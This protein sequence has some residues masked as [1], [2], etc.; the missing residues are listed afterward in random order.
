M[1]RAA[2]GGAFAIASALVGCVFVADLGTDG[3]QLAPQDAAG[4][5]DAGVCDGDASCTVLTL[6]CASAAEC[7]AGSVCCLAS[8]GTTCQPGPPCGTG[9]LGYQICATST[10]CGDASCVSQQCSF[11]G[12]APLRFSACGLIPFCSP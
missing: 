5:Q 11:A 7:D 9:T 8:T 12:G 1:R 2:I 4:S 3:Y 6:G 10:E